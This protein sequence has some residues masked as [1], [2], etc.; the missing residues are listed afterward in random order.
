VVATSPSAFSTSLSASAACAV[1]P[2]L[3]CSYRPD[4]DIAN[5]LTRLSLA[6]ELKL[7]A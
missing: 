1:A 2:G 6:L 5:A 7:A 4:A 3:F